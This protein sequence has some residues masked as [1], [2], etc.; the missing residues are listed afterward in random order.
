M[1]NGKTYTDYKQDNFEC[2]KYKQLCEINGEDCTKGIDD[3]IAVIEQVG[4]NNVVEDGSEDDELGLRRETRQAAG[5]EELV[6]EQ[7]EDD[8]FFLFSSSDGSEHNCGATI[9]SDRF[10]VAAAHCYDTFDG[11]DGAL[12]ITQNTLR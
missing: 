11:P 2:G 1:V 3:D 6:E 7:E 10:L 9:V 4:G 8:R 5:P 12:K